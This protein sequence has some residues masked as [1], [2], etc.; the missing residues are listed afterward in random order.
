MVTRKG[1]CC[2]IPMEDPLKYL[3]IGMVT[4]DKKKI[5]PVPLAEAFPEVFDLVRAE[6]DMRHGDG[7][8]GTPIFEGS[9]LD[10]PWGTLELLRH[11]RE[12][13]ALSQRRDIEK[14]EKAVEGAKPQG[15]VSG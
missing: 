3:M 15:I 1:L 8:W 14:K 7:G 9:S 13:R 11:I 12:Q 6:V 10:W 5:C 2:L 4:I